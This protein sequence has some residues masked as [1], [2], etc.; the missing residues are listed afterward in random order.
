MRTNYQV[1]FVRGNSRP[2]GISLVDDANQLSGVIGSAPVRF[3]QTEGA[4]VLFHLMDQDSLDACFD[5]RTVIRLEKLGFSPRRVTPTYAHV[6]ASMY[7]GRMVL[8]KLGD[9]EAILCDLRERNSDVDFVDAFRPPG[10]DFVRISLKSR[11]DLEKILGVGLKI[12]FLYLPPSSIREFKNIQEQRT[13]R[14]KSKRSRQD[15]SRPST[16]TEVPSMVASII[17]STLERE[18]A[19]NLQCPSGD[20]RCNQARDA[21]VLALSIVYSAMLMSKS[22]EQGIHNLEPEFR[23]SYLSCKK[24][25]PQKQCGYEAVNINIC[26]KICN[27]ISYLQIALCE[28][29]IISSLRV[30]TVV[31]RRYAITHVTSRMKNPSNESTELLFKMQLPKMAFVSS[32]IMEIEGKNYTS[33]IEEKEKARHTYHKAKGKGKTSVLVEQGV[34]NFQVSANVAAHQKVTFFLKYEEFLHRVKGVYNLMLNVRPGHEVEELTMKVS[35][36]D[37]EPITDLTI[38]KTPGNEFELPTLLDKDMEIEKGSSLLALTYESKEEVTII[39]QW[40]NTGVG[41]Y[42]PS[43]NKLSLAYDLQRKI[44]GGEVKVE[45]DF[46][47]HYFSPEGLPTMRKH[48]VFVIDIS[49][50]MGDNKKMDNVKKAM[51]AILKDMREDD[52]FEVIVFSSS[53]RTLGKY[54][55]TRPSLQEI[56]RKVRYLQPDGATNINQA[57]LDAFYSFEFREE[58]TAKQIV[59][60]TDGEPTAG[61]T[62]LSTIRENVMAANQ[63]KIGIFSLAFGENADLQFL[64]KISADSGGFARMIYEHSE[65]SKQLTGFYEEISSPLL[66]DL[67]IIY[68]DAVDKNTLVLPG[69]LT[70]FEG[71][72]VVMAGMKDPGAVWVSPIVSALGRDGELQLEVTRNQILPWDP[73]REN[74]IE[75]MWAYMT[76]QDIL[77]MM[78]VESDMEKKERLK[79]RAIEIALKYNFVTRVTSLVVVRPEDQNI[80]DEDDLEYEEDLKHDLEYEEDLQH[81]LEYEEDLQY[82][83]YHQGYGRDM[84]NDRSIYHED[85]DYYDGTHSSQFDITLSAGKDNNKGWMISIILMMVL[86]LLY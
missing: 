29:G 5:K 41:E 82:Y 71:D 15:A 40:S 46:F 37:T 4:N 14:T 56:L 42:S 69:L 60:L 24:D 28:V 8:D 22:K 10:T 25:R 52:T 18:A 1:V 63:R 31:D 62:D 72:E 13:Q 85:Y 38:L 54:R 17:G 23:G 50:S 61:V 75:R 20:E 32:L 19:G 11:S 6:R 68:D 26:T 57:L 65:P 21:Q 74:N 51:E 43:K 73:E 39:Y 59:F 35:L 2:D 79:A 48:T 33:L 78:D 30:S 27:V 49:G 77:D 44:D 34:K 16:C 80:Q 45:G 83:Q 86:H 36:K 47:A 9:K 76:V 84:E 64:Q 66:T 67:T 58:P 81:D 12:S 3:A 70:Y 53:T 7:V 55:G